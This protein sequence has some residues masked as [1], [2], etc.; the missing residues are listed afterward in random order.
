MAGDWLKFDKATPDKP[1]VFAI[2]SDLG[3]DPDAVV[4]K[5]MRIWSWFDSHT[6]D[7]NARC[8]T[9]AL[10]DRIAGVTGFVQSMQ[11]TG[12]VV[13]TDDGVSLP[14]FGFHCGETAKS[15]AQNNKR[16]S[17]YRAC[18]GKS[19]TSALQNHVPE[20]RREEKKR[21]EE[22]Q[23]Q[24]HTPDGDAPKKPK[25]RK[26]PIPD[27]FALSERVKAWAIE[28]GYTRIEERL[29]YF[30][31]KAKASGYQ[32]ADWDQAFMNSIRED[33]AKLPPIKSAN[34]GRVKL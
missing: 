23:K 31:G 2:A 25:S 11:K 12:W 18:N 6:E 17:K 15:R 28:K 3:I 33:W 21:E 34:G 9:S 29:D 27:D 14:N 30:I 24:K 19:V 1:E 16:I 4:G 32:Y 10:L 7:G 20:K 22:K 26:H 8:V 5:L 13:V